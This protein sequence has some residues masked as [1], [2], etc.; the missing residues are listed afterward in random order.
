MVRRYI[1]EK[2]LQ[3]GEAEQP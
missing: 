1:P 2:L 3:S